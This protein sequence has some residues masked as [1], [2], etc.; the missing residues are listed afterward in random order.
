VGPGDL[1]VAATLHHHR[2][3]DVASQLHRTPPW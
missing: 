3:D 2:V 1:P